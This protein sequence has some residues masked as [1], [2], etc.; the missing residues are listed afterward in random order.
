MRRAIA[1]ATRGSWPSATAQG[2]ATLRHD[3]RHRRRFKLTTDQ[4][5][6]FLL[7]LERPTRL[8]DGDGLALDDGGYLLVRA[9]AEDCVLVRCAD[10]TTMT[11]IAWHLGNRHLPVQIVADGLLIRA[12]HVIVDM[13]RGLGATAEPR[14]CAFDPEAGAYADG[15]GHHH[16]DDDDDHHRDHHHHD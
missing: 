5:E 3:D 4:G 13:V 11:R 8:A 16:D 10:P 9:A 14:R 7:D 2:S 12:D 15:G 6:V 1:V